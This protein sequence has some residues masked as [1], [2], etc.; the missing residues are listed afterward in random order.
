MSRFNESRLEQELLELVRRAQE[1][2]RNAVAITNEQSK[3][4]NLSLDH[5]D[6]AH[7]LRMAVQSE[8]AAL[9]TYS[10]ALGAFTDLVLLRQ[11]PTEQFFFNSLLNMAI[12]ATAADKGTMQVF[13][14]AE[15]VLRIVAHRGFGQA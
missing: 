1:A 11:K 13:D 6:G 10:Q 4:A 12:S 7:E 2:Y 8:R 5:P 3:A 9:D 15:S 14:P